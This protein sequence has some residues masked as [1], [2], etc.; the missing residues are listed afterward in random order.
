[1]WREAWSTSV[2]LFRWLPVALLISQLHKWKGESGIAKT[3][4]WGKFM[5]AVPSLWFLRFLVPWSRFRPLEKNFPYICQLVFEQKKPMALSLLSL[6]ISLR[7]GVH[8][9]TVWCSMDDLVNQSCLNRLLRLLFS[10]SIISSH[11][12]KYTNCDKNCLLVSKLCPVQAVL[13]ESQNVE[14]FRETS[15]GKVWAEC[16]HQ[17]LSYGIRWV[18]VMIA[19]RWLSSPEP[20]QSLSLVPYWA[21]HT[22]ASINGCCLSHIDLFIKRLDF[23]WVCPSKDWISQVLCSHPFHWLQSWLVEALWSAFSVISCQG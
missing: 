6:K 2:D 20:T 7:G 21:P 11:S 16:I 13:P 4:H 8:T 17:V 3:P 10:L 1:M 15:K 22:H 5:N 12:E 23:C 18:W 9:L 14:E 19:I